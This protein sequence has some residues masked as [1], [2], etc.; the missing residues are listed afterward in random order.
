[1][2]TSVLPELLES[3]P[4]ESNKLDVK[5]FSRSAIRRIRAEVL[6]DGI[7]QTTSTVGNSA[8]YP[9]AKAVQIAGGRTSTYFLTTFGRATRETVCSCE[10]SMEPNLSSTSPPKW[11]YRSNKIR[12]GRYI[13]NELKAKT[14]PEQIIKN[15]YIR[16]Y[17]RE[18]KSEELMPS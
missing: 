15:L 2:K 5:N 6:L 7:S 1:M 11:R 4:N 10:V 3:K 18:V 12:S 9:G 13:E 17:S 8:R 16:C 14:P